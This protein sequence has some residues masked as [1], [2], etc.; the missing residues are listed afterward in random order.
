MQNQSLNF[1]HLK[2]D[3]SDIKSLID[4]YDDI[5]NFVF[6]YYSSGAG[7]PVQLIAYV[8]KGLDCTVYTYAEESNILSHHGEHLLEVSGIA[9]MSNNFIAIEEMKTLIDYPKKDSGHLL[10]KPKLNSTNHVYYSVEYFLNDGEPNKQGGI[11]TTNP[12]P[13]ATMTTI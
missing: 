7:K 5:N 11:S 13:P 12:S 8:R 4:K 2:Y 3:V 1:Y 10:F 6:S 9:I